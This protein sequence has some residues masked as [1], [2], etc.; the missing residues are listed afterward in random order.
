MYTENTFLT[1]TYRDESLPEN[2]SL[3]KT[4]VPAYMKR[5]RSR[6]ARKARREGKHPQRLRYYHC[7]EY[8]DRTNRPHYHALLFGYA[9]PDQELYKTTPSGHRLFTSYQADKDW[10]HGHVIIGEVSFDSAAYVARYI[11]KKK[12][13]VLADKYYERVLDDSGL[14][15]RVEPEY[16]TQSNGLGKE[17]WRKFHRD[18]YPRDY[19]TIE[20]RKIKPPR[21]YDELLKE[22]DPEMY[23]EVIAKRKQ[24][25]EESPDN[26]PW[27]LEAR[28]TVKKAQIGF[29]ERNLE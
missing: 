28:E 11:M 22:H 23:E 26:K 24:L 3:E 17:W 9:Y 20:G 1:L 16:T 14:V 8:G 12:T 19:V 5:L 27:R 4:H 7:G 21:Y 25:A 10:T 2:G 15:V 13:G 18:V 6:L 29:L